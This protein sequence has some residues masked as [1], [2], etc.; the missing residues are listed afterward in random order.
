MKSLRQTLL[1]LTVLLLSGSQAF[2]GSAGVSGGL[3]L[4]ETT[5]A[6]PAS[7]G[8][9]FTGVTNDIAGFSYN[10]ASLG[11]IKNGQASF[12][13]QKGLLEDSYGHFSIGGGNS[14]GKGYGLSVGYYNAGSIE[15]NDG[16]TT[17]T[18]TA[19]KDLLV[20]LGMSRSLGKMSYG[21]S[22][23]FL[24]SKLVEQ[25]SA[26]AYAA[27][28]GVLMP[29]GNRMHLG[30]AARNIGTQLKY[31]DEGDSLP[32]I[33]D[34]GLAMN[35]IPGAHSTTL[36]LNTPYYANEKSLLPGVGLETLVGPM[37]IRAGYK[38]REGGNQFT[39]GAGFQLG[40]TNFDYAFG[41]V[42]DLSAEHKVSVSLHFGNSHPSV[43]EFTAK[44][45]M[46]A[47]QTAQRLENNE[48]TKSGTE[49]TSAKK[50]VAEVPQ[51]APARH[52]LET[53]SNKSAMT[54]ARRIYVARA[55]DSLTSIARKVYGD[56]REWKRIYAA[57][58]HLMGDD[59]TIE[60]GQKIILP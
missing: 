33:Y 49:K 60:A 37:A 6:R 35:L 59:Q 50:E 53:M 57:N 7:M 28:L 42:K 58:K 40:S 25:Y 11:T 10:P 21:A 2:A 44:P 46:K 26:T 51:I 45:E 14:K 56:S 18:V 13:Y 38:K 22:V 1:S 24:Q 3:T 41:L 30:L 8:E 17:R 9:A 54:V 43:T 12:L 32:R 4:L 23:K 31:V 27:D 5:D 47:T 29:I 20:S 16:V 36:M 48:N 19:Q 15:V 52:T 55:G 34:M 39:V